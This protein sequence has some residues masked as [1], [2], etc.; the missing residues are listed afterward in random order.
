MLGGDRNLPA[1]PVPRAASLR[2]DFHDGPPVVAH[3][4]LGA[5]DKDKEQLACAH[6]PKLL[7]KKGTLGTG[8]R[9]QQQQHMLGL[10][11]NQSIN[12]NE[13]SLAI[14]RAAAQCEV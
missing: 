5:L 9:L 12:K 2:I 1:R 14:C 8:V 13:F 4:R 6:L 10:I 3:G 7:H 11:L